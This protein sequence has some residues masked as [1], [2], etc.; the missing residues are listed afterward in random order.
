MEDPDRGWKPNGRPQSTVARNFLSEL[1]DLF[2][3]DSSIDVLDKTV[4]QKKQ[5]VT[6]RAQELEA[7]EA[8]LR[9]TEERLKQARSSP[10]SYTRKDSERQSPFQSTLPEQDKAHVEEPSS[11]LTQP[12]KDM[13]GA[14]PETPTSYNS[15]EYV[16][17]DRPHTAQNE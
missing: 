3:I 8:R 5:A 17:V 12:A 15:T 9:E 7:L 11:P 2:K 13:P 4:H 10:P 6:S 14:L 1:D 16:L